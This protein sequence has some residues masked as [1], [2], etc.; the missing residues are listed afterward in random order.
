MKNAAGGTNSGGIFYFGRGPSDGCRSACLQNQKLLGGV[1]NIQT[2]IVSEDDHI[3]DPHAEAAGKIDTGLCGN[4]CSGGQ[5]FLAVG[6]GSWH[7]VEFHPQAVAKSMAEIRS[8]ACVGNRK[9]TLPAVQNRQGGA[10]CRG[11]KGGDC[12]GGW[13]ERR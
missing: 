5:N 12:S 6:A 4:N 2:S 9:A 3:F 1:G 7:F 8:I 11:E 13:A 10:F